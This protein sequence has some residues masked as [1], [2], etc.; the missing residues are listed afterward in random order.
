MSK[1][2]SEIEYSDDNPWR[3]EDTLRELYYSKRLTLPEIAEKFEVSHQA[4]LYWFKKHS[5]ERRSLKDYADGVFCN[6]IEPPKQKAQ[7]QMMFCSY[8][9]QS[10][11]VPLNRVGDRKYCSRECADNGYTKT[12][13]KKERKTCENCEVVFKALPQRKYCC[14]ECYWEDLYD[15]GRGLA[16]VWRGRENQA[17]WREGVFER[18]EYTCQR[19][20]EKGGEL[21]AHHIVPVSDIVEGIESRTEILEH[22]LFNELSNGITVCVDC[23]RQIHSGNEPAELN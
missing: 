22:E 4:I 17:G 10:F 12:D 8:C 11:T 16:E 15:G 7:R 1:H 9:G 3:D 13:F 14:H 23:H 18:D 5:I 21:N 6:D 20:G 2:S 19:C